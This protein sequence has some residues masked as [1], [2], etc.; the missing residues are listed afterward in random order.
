M[1]LVSYFDQ[2]PKVG[3]LDNGKVWDLRGLYARYLYEAQRVSD[4]RELAAHVVPT[5]MA[6]FIRFNHNNLEYMWEA[7]EYITSRAKELGD[8]EALARP[9]KS[10]RLLPPVPSP[11]KIICC[12]S[13]Y[14]EYLAEL[15]MPKEKWPQDVKISFLKQPTCLIGHN[16]TILFPADSVEGDYENE[17]TIVIG[18]YCSDVSEKDASRYIFGYTILNDACVRDIPTW[19][20]GLDSPRGK[21]NDTQAPC[22]PCITPAN[23]LGKHPNSLNFKTEVDG[24]LRQKGNTSGLSWT[25]ERIV[26]FIS[27]YQKLMPGDLIATGSTKGNAHTSGKFLKPGQRIRMEVEGIGVLEN[28]VGK[29]TWTSE[30]LPMRS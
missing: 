17:L 23:D 29:K 16:D 12:G 11:T 24:E 9:L 6:R 7:F 27:R 22:G 13:S 8:V 21:A 25:V 10:T 18:R 5:D 2:G 4:C 14:A 1:K 19:T 15:N 30:L 20:G 3:I 26:A 28:V